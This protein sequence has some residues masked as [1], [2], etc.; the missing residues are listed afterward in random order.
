VLAQCRSIVQSSQGAAVMAMHDVFS[1]LQI[2]DQIA[3][4]WPAKLNASPWVLRKGD[5]CWEVDL[6]HSLL[7][8]ARWTHEFGESDGV[9]QLVGELRSSLVQP[10]AVGGGV[11]IFKSDGKTVSVPISSCQAGLQEKLRTEHSEP[12]RYEEARRVF[13]G[14]T[15][16]VKN[17]ENTAALAEIPLEIT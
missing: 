16:P 5:S 7:C 17:Q 1:A 11:T 4:L 8:L 10:P 13:I 12:V 3:L 15:W 14:L 9:R 2:A 6:L